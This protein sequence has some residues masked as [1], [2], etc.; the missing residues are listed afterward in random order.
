MQQI[1]FDT[2]TVIAFSINTLF[3][4]SQRTKLQHKGNQVLLSSSVT[5]VSF[6]LGELLFYAQ[7]G[8]WQSKH[9]MLKGF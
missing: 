8:T 2:Y 4:I 5:G 7:T 6:C 3:N 9:Y 1:E